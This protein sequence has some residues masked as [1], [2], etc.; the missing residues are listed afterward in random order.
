MSDSLFKKILTDITETIEDLFI[1]LLAIVL[2]VFMA[3]Q[4]YGVENAGTEVFW[5]PIWAFGGIVIIK[6][7]KDSFFSLTKK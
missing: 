5:Y 4:F 2:I 3:G 6:L 1:A 7:V